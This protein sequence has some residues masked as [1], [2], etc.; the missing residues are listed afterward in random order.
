MP[1][2]DYQCPVC[3]RIAELSDEREAWCHCEC[4]FFEGASPAACLKMERLPSAP[5]FT[6]K[7]FNAKN[8]Y[9][10]GKK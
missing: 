9:S 1:R 3:L 5:A 8:G 7:G 2:H 4:G 10:G 6:V